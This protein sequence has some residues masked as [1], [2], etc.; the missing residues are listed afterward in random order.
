MEKRPNLLSRIWS[1]VA[2]ADTWSWLF[3]LLPKPVRQ[4]LQ[5]NVWRP[6]V[7]FVPPIV[8][9]LIGIVEG[10]PVFW[11][12]VGTLGALAFAFWISFQIQ[13]A[14]ERF[15]A[16]RRAFKVKAIAGSKSGAYYLPAGS[17]GPLAP[18]IVY[19]K[20][21]VEAARFLRNCSATVIAVKWLNIVKG[22]VKG[23]NKTVRLW[24][25]LA[26]FPREIGWEPEQARQRT[27]DLVPGV[28]R[29]LDVAVLDQASPT[30]FMIATVDEQPRLEHPP[31]WYKID[32]TLAS[33]SDDPTVQNVEMVIG[34]GKRKC[35]PPPLDALLWKD[36]YEGLLN[37]DD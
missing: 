15:M 3:S 1:K 18:S 5:D 8:A 33:E 19:A 34:L 7:T 24:H 4:W 26:G 37:Y 11:L 2:N 17:A 27:R 21:E 29:R 23:E 16:R 28:P 25:V 30:K 14:I 9:L 6:I 12:L 32:I 20:L 10:I 35:P 22:K 36:E 13:S 31:A